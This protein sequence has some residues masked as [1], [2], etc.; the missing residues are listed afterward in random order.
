ML[1]RESRLLS[2]SHTQS[3]PRWADLALH[4]SGR[5]R[6]WTRTCTSEP[7]S[8]EVPPPVSDEV[9]ATPLQFLKGVGPRRAADLARAACSPSKI[10]CTVFR[11]AT[12]TA[13][14]SS[15]SPR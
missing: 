2:A 9:L 14:G 15:R 3:R 13:A 7:Q 11:S 12:K 4:V 1:L 8:C 10:C 6:A 5:N